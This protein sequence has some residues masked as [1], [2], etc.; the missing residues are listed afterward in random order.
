MTIFF[1]DKFLFLT[2]LEVGNSKFKVLEDMISNEIWFP[3]S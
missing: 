2:V 3:G 1:Y